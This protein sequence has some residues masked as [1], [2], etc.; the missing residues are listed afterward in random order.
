VLSKKRIYV[1]ICSIL[2]A[3]I[4]AAIGTELHA[5]TFRSMRN[6]VTSLQPQKLLRHLIE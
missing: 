3:A 2:L 6:R 1:V 5:D 4:E